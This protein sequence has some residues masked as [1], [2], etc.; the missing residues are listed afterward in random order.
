M[1]PSMCKPL[2]RWR[3][4]HMHAMKCTPPPPPC[5]KNLLWAEPVLIPLHSLKCPSTLLYLAKSYSFLRMMQKNPSV[6]PSLVL[7]P[8]TDELVIPSWEPPR[9]S[10]KGFIG[11]SS[12]SGTCLSF[13]ADWELLPWSR[14][15]FIHVWDLAS[16]F[17]NHAHTEPCLDS[18]LL[19]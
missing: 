19:N 4:T 8:L 10:A 15:Y 2:W 6:K 17:L 5:Q 16:V 1:P 3:S 9:H 13:L 7:L 12:P 11:A 18:Y 14:T